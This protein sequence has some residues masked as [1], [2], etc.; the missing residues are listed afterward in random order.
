MCLALLWPSGWPVGRDS[1]LPPVRQRRVRLAGPVLAQR[2][3]AARRSSLQHEHRQADP[4]HRARGRQGARVRRGGAPCPQGRP[5]RGDRFVGRVGRGAQGRARAPA[6]R[7]ELA[8]PKPPGAEP[9]TGP[10]TAHD[11]DCETS[12]TLEEPM[13]NQHDEESRIIAASPVVHESDMLP[14]RR[15][16]SMLTR[17]RFDSSAVKTALT[18]AVQFAGRST[19]GYEWVA[20]GARQP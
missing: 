17:T 12:A 10:R 9:A 8:P 18:R 19:K 6:Q 3:S 1:R 2:R 11:L 15:P 5:A 7:L 4:A 13:Q 14:Y 16:R 20:A